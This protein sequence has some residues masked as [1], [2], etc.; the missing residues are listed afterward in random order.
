MRSAMRR[1]KIDYANLAKV[2][3]G[4]AA[5]TGITSC[6]NLRADSAEVVGHKIQSPMI[7]S[8]GTIGRVRGLKAHHCANSNPNKSGGR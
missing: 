3:R 5:S 6:R 1:K 7:I 4:I 2:D 8:P